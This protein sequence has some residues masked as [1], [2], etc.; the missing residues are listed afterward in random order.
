MAL[1]YLAMTPGTEEPSAVGTK[2]PLSL[3]RTP[4]P[5]SQADGHAPPSGGAGKAESKSWKEKP[6]A[7][8]A[9]PSQETLR[10]R[11]G[12]RCAALGGRSFA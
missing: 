11:L 9:F 4:K 10:R 12:N 8:L 2:R 5:L 7:W 3:P 1:T 6:G